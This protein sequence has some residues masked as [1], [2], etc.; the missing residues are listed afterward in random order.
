MVKTKYV[1][2]VSTIQITSMHNHNSKYAQVHHFIRFLSHLELKLFYSHCKLIKSGFGHYPSFQSFRM[3]KILVPWRMSTK[4]RLIQN[5]W[6]VKSA[7]S[8]FPSSCPL[9][10]KDKTNQNKTNKNQIFFWSVQPS[11]RFF[12]AIKEWSMISDVETSDKSDN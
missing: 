3:D 11:F 12:P 10:K 8:E 1:S 9:P 6:R 5:L 2:F 7:K 4:N